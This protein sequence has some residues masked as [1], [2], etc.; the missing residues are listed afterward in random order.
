MQLLIRDTLDLLDRGVCTGVDMA[1]IVG[2]WSWAVLSC[3][4]AFA[5][6]NAVYR[7]I[8]TVSLPFGV[9]FNV[10]WW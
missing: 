2:R 6:F 4:P 8:E 9:L 1:H 10:S 3:R 5:V 7:F